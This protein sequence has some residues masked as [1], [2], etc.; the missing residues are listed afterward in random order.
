MLRIG[1]TDSTVFR[2]IFDPTTNDFGWP[3]ST[4]QWRH[5]AGSASLASA[6][7]CSREELCVASFAFWRRSFL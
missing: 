4:A 3:F 1:L 5:F 6:S 2:R 7:Q